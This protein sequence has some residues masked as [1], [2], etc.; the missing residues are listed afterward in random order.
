MDFSLIGLW[1][2]DPGLEV[3]ILSMDYHFTSQILLR[4]WDIFFYEGSV[5]LFRV[6]L[7]MLK[8]KASCSFQQEVSPALVDWRKS[9]VINHVLTRLWRQVSGRTV[10]PW[11]N[12]TPNSSQL[13]PRFQLG[14]GWVSFG[15]PLGSRWLEFDQLQMFAQLKPGFP[16]FGQLEPSCFVLLGD[17]AGL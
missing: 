12:G 7:G 5:T 4:V 17:C 14:W 8:M 11:P 6:T 16:P 9:H 3:R 1:T 10:K 15:H 2:T 13:K